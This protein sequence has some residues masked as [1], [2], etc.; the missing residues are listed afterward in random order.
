VANSVARPGL[1]VKIVGTHSG[2]SPCADGASHQ[3]I[4]DVAL[5]RALPNMR[6]V[7]PADAPE[8]VQALMALV[9]WYGPAYLRL[10]RGDSPVVYDEECDLTLGEANT[11]REGADATIIAN[12]V[13]VSKALHAAEMLTMD[14]IDV[15]VVDMHTIKPLDKDAIE[16]A[17]EETGAIVTAEEHS[18]IGG[19]G[20]AVAETL[21]ES[22]PTPMSRV[23]I[24]DRFGESSRSYDDL[25]RKLGL[26]SEAIA[27]A[28]REVISRRD[29]RE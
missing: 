27:D 6:V 8:A 23:G 15:K 10:G 21:A 29:E 13:M 14:R 24:R 20:S 12:G 17:A 2:L 18:I 4:V 16:K 11:L 28:V 3:A 25:M 9:E 26:T 19:L 5:M 7:V 1:N 22:R